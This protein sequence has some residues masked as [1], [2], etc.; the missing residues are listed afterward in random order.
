MTRKARK[1]TDAKWKDVIG[2]ATL[3]AAAGRALTV[4]NRYDAAGTGRRMRGWTPPS[5]GPN[6][7]T[8]GLQKIR[9]RARDAGRNDWAGA[10]GVQ[11]WTT[12]L[13][14]IGIIPRLSNVKNLTLKT[15]LAE[16][17]DD[18]VKVSD[19]DGVLNFYGQT[20]LAVRSWLE[21][22]EVFGRFRYRR[23]DSGM[24]VPMQ[25]QLIEADF[26][27]LF[28]SDM[29]PGMAKNH[30]IRQGIEQN[31]AG[32]KVAYWV[33][34]EHPGDGFS[35]RGDMSQL[36]RVPAAEM[37]HMFEPT[38]PGQLRG[39]SVLAPVLA[40]LRNV[41]D[42]DDAVLERQKL[43]NLFVGFITRKLPTLA[44]DADIDPLTM[45]EIETN[46]IGEP[47]A[48]LEP[49]LM[50]QLDD[51]ED[52]K[53]ANPPEAGTTYSDYMRTQHLG[54]AAGQ[55]L[56]Y[57][58]M[59]GDIK[60]VSDRTLRVLI[61]EFRRLAEQR[62]WQ[63][64]IPMWCQRVR[65]AWAGAAVMSGVLAAGD[66]KTATAVEWAP[67][68]W[69]YIHPVQDAQGKK[70]EVDAGFRSRSS[71]IAERG[72]DPVAVDDERQE[73]VQ[74]EKDRDLYV[75][76]NAAPGGAAPKDDGDEDG[77]DN[78]EYS[79]PATPPGA[80]RRAQAAR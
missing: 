54:T 59:S 61:N 52:V 17:W 39:V 23:A 28:D 43:A 6:L 4:R 15:A 18:W 9:D 34:R 27:P 26:V 2:P 55:A 22:G 24:A 35:F 8:A 79:A 31:R 21:S 36:I 58:I 1:I 70:I 53:F 74:R 60:E 40:R 11:R 16:A 47:L 7:A 57:E 10:A 48:A 77:I 32:M 49:G 65:D 76:P 56:P 46:S 25:V 19:A 29:W 12:N 20:T 67:H 68:G 66:L 62:Q 41:G 80:K 3:P 73:D 75:D 30:R 38:R 63:I 44:D 33:Y 78:D 71:V 72:D 64:I 13:V 5:S 42:Y 69:A 14:G 45:Q 51:G 50:Q 37:I